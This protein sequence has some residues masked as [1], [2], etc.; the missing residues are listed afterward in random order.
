[1]VIAL[2]S[3]VIY[4]IFILAADIVFVIIFPQLTAVLY[5]PKYSNPVGAIS[6]FF[7]GLILRIGA[8][9]PIIRLPAFIYFPFYDKE[10]L[11][12]FRTFAM[13]VS[14]VTT[15]AVTSV[16]R[17]KVMRFFCERFEYTVVQQ[18]DVHQSSCSNTESQGREKGVM[19]DR[20]V[21]DEDHMKTVN[22]KN[23]I[24]EIQFGETI[25]RFNR[26][27][28]IELDVVMNGR[29]RKLTMDNHFGE[30]YEERL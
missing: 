27:D 2:W 26:L 21:T 11:F 14:F 9:E 13:L 24:R 1:M 18:D 4:G 16:S 23:G 15:L 6:G 29:F 3:S 7:I 5:F 22:G 17:L 19:G 10:Q 8:G 12:P 20:R 25:E 28:D 30:K